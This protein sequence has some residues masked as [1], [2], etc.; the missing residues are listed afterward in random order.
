VLSLAL[1]CSFARGLERSLKLIY[2][3]LVVTEER[4]GRVG[5]EN[6]GDSLP[7]HSARHPA[8]PATPKLAG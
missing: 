3:L 2:H 4:E 1:V 6:S 5:E 8:A 7:G